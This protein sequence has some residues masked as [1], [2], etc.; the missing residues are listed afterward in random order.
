MS[1]PS[2]Y[3]SQISDDASVTS[4][5]PSYHSHASDN[6][7]A[8]DLFHQ[9]TF[10]SM[11]HHRATAYNHLHPPLPADQH[12]IFSHHGRYQNSSRNRFQ[13]TTPPL[14]QYT[15]SIKPDLQCTRI[16]SSELSSLHAVPGLQYPLPC[17]PI[18]S[19]EP[20]M[21]PPGMPPDVLHYSQCM[22]PVVHPGF[23][24]LL[25]VRYI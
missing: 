13:Y 6:A 5:L 14:N 1:L 12:P 8:S 3:R 25:Q 17:Y 10:N 22:Q 7:A 9:N 23:H 16:S 24:Q 4:L 18:P 2:W 19:V 20:Y 15:R 21:M 11:Q